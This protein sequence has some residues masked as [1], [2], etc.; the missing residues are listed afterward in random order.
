LQPAHVD[1]VQ[2]AS[3][4]APEVGSTPLLLPPDA[5]AWGAQSVSPASGTATV[6]M[7]SVATP[8]KV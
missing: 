5:N 4:I 7:S 3:L 1:I 6:P 2:A 8:R